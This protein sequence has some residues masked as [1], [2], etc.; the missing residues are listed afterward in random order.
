MKPII[1]VHAHVFRGRDIPLKGYLLSRRYEEWY[2]RLLAPILF[3]VIA[4][5]IRREEKSP[6]LCGLVL[7]L[8]Y[9]Y[10][11]QGYR[12]WAAILSKKEVAEIAQ[13][14]V[15][16]FAPG[17][18][19]LYVPLMIDYEYWFKSPAEPHIATQIDAVYRDVV[20]PFRGQIHPF[21]PFDPARELAYRNH[22]PGPTDPD[23][24]PP[25]KYSSLELAKDAVRN[26]GFVGVKVYNTLG[27][28]PLGNAAVDEKRGRIFRNNG[29]DR[30]TAFTGDELDQ[31]LREL[32]GFCVQ[33]QVPVIAHCLSDGIEAYPGASIDFGHPAYWR[34]VLEQFP[35]LHLDLAHLGWSHT[36]SYYPK[37]R[38]WTQL[39]NSMLKQAP[40][41][42]PVTVQAGKTWVGEICQMLQ[43]YRYLY[44]D[45]AHH[46]VVD[47]K[48]VDRYR[49]SYQGMCADY[50][51]LLQK[52][53]LF[54]IDWH[55]IARLDNYEHFQ[56]CYVQLLKEGDLFDD[57][58]IAAFLGGN[59]L[60]FMGLL[61]L[62]TPNGWTKNRERLQRFYRDNQMEEPEWFR[63]TGQVP[64]P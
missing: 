30:Y 28:R 34:P 45:V 6:I 22:L 64:S 63:E 32:Y 15:E 49:T 17:G 39:V 20:L 5:C 42:K 18:I 10:L 16:T 55:V 41:G 35:D 26:K 57:D 25:E 1:D 38:W 31:V 12:R 7:E 44:A 8:V 61:P 37:K 13:E 23:D 11:G 27:Y 54:G 58:A 14:L 9:K 4:R 2:I 21:V 47:P 53:L 3:S 62:G 52:K 51:G 19:Q 40:G 56:E 50:P 24:G 36:E 43:D 33:E 46:E 60:D 59:A 29:M 48:E